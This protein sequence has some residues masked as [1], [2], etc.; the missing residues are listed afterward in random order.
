MVECI[1]LVGLSGELKTAL[2]L[3]A[4]RPRMLRDQILI[5]SFESIGY[6]FRYLLFDL[7]GMMM[8]NF[9]M[10]ARKAV[11]ATLSLLVFHSQTGVLCLIGV[12]LSLASIS[13]EL[14]DF[15]GKT[16]KMKET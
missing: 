9:W 15:I 5:A 11:S 14:K 2:I 13:L 16:P 3:F 12:F 10:T 8:V 1:S 7:Q 6:Y 4:Q